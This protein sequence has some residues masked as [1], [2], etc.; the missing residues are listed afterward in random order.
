MET[1]AFPPISMGSL[2]WSPVTLFRDI[3]FIT[4]TTINQT[5]QGCFLYYTKSR[6]VTSACQV[7]PSYPLWIVGHDQLNLLPEAC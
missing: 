3:I 4:V 7:M 5:L 6:H 2:E 1:I